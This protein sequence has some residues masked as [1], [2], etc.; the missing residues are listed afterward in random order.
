MLLLR[1]SAQ[2]KEKRAVVAGTGN[3]SLSGMQSHVCNSDGIPLRRVRCGD[4]RDVRGW[5]NRSRNILRKLL[6]VA[7]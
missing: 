3:G 1:S 7:E 4:L 2:L 6:R 5:K